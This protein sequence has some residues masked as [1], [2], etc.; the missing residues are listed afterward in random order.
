MKVSGKD[1]ASHMAKN[2]ARMHAA[3]RA[4]YGLDM[5]NRQVEITLKAATDKTWEIIGR[6]K[7]N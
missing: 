4:E 3:V 2:L 7:P 5:A 6:G 1:L